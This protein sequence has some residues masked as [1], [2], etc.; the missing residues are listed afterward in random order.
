MTA[1][2]RQYLTFDLIDRSTVQL[3][4]PPYRSLPNLLVPSISLTDKTCSSASISVSDTDGSISTPWSAETACARSRILINY[5]SSI[6][7]PH[8]V[9]LDHHTSFP[10]E[11]VGQTAPACIDVFVTKPYPGEDFSRQGKI[12]VLS[13]S[14]CSPDPRCRLFTVPQDLRPTKD[15]RILCSADGH[16]VE[17]STGSGHV[18]LVSPVPDSVMLDNVKFYVPP[19]IGR[20]GRKSVIETV[21]PGLP[22]RPNLVVIDASKPHEV[23]N[24][25]LLPRIG[26]VNEPI[27]IGSEIF[28]DKSTRTCRMV[29]ACI[30]YG[31]LEMLGGFAQHGLVVPESLISMDERKNSDIF[32]T[33]LDCPLD[34]TSRE[35]LTEL[36]LSKLPAVVYSRLSGDSESKC[37][38]KTVSSRRRLT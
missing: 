7:G 21:R 3:S 19:S 12:V 32:C 38:A 1:Q 13:G 2:R 4:V 14:L 18:D 24:F 5:I 29:V 15:I 25:L 10:V 37:L 23:N 34:D 22:N 20:E 30:N 11:I 28:D 27:L 9:D 8:S 16:Y 31:G 36:V 26:T 6:K 35:Q 33:M 17:I